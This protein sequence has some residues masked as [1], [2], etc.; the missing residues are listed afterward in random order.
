VVLKITIMV[1]LYISNIL[2]NIPN[3]PSAFW[4]H[5]I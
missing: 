3:Y 4:S 5:Q 1:K 2:F